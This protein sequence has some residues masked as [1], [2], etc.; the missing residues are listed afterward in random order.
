[1][2]SSAEPPSNGSDAAAPN[3]N[4][5]PSDRE[6]DAALLARAANG[7]SRAFRE[8]VERH[9]R[10]AHSVAY[11]LVRNPEDAREVVQEAFIRVFRH[12]AEFAGQASFSTWLYRIV[13]N[14]SIDL[15]RKRSPGKAI[16]FDESVDTEGAPDELV[17]R[18]EGVDPF[19][20]LDRKRL[21]EAMHKA[22]EQLPPYHRAVILLRELEGLSYE[23]MAATLDVSKGT[24]MS[25]L[26]HA[27]RKMQK[28]LKEQLGDEVP[29]VQES[30]P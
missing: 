20:T 22:L 16:E 11:G 27:R 10:R 18:R 30:E 12:R 1:M 29:D 25:R 24:I 13:V 8:L 9:Q 6:I 7:D 14:L 5:T 19:A 28:L 26:F 21:I 17:P 2:N 3:A 4:P 15:L 23:E